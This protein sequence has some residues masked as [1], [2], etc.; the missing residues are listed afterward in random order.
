MLT[1]AGRKKKRARSTET[2]FEGSFSAAQDRKNF[3]VNM[4]LA[5]WPDRYFQGGI[6][7]EFKVLDGW[8]NQLEREQPAILTYL[9]NMGDLVFYCALVVEDHTVIFKPWHEIKGLKSL[10]NVERYHY[11]NKL[12]LKEMFDAATKDHK[13]LDRRD[14]A[15]PEQADSFAGRQHDWLT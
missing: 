11:K 9:E 7:I 5:G 2:S 13:F 15:E 4:L 3:H 10:K 8:T 12:D 14:R 6:W 1:I